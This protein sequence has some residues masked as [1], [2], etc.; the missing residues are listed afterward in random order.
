MAAIALAIFIGWS[1]AWIFVDRRAHEAPA[2]QGFSM[3]ILFPAFLS[4]V[5]ARR[6]SQ[7]GCSRS[8]IAR[9]PTWCPRPRSRQRRDH[10]GG[11]RTLLAGWR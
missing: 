9:S 8:N 11:R 3:M 10:C 5:R 6:R 1:M 4:N 7:A 2:V